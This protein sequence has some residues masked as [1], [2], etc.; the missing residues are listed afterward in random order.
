ME[1]VS[2]IGREK[3]GRLRWGVLAMLFGVTIINYAVRAALS[4]AAPSLSKDLGIDPLQLGIVFSAFGWSYVIAQVPG[5]WLLDRFGAPRVYL[6]VIVA[7]SLITVAHGT[8]VWLSGT[9]AVTA[10]FAL[11]FLVG[12]AEAPSFPANARVVASWFP[13]RERGTAS[14]VFN[15]AQYFATVLFAPL[16]GWIVADF[17]WPWVFV[18]MGAL[19]LVVSLFWSRVVRD[20]RDHPRLGAGELGLLIEGGALV[21]PVAPQVDAAAAKAENRRKMRVLL[22]T[23]T[24]WGLYSGQFFINTLTYFFIT[25]FPVYL[26]QERGL[27]VMK[28][29]LFATMPAVCGFIGGVLGGIW[30]DWLLR[31]GVSLTWARKVPVVAGMLGA[32]TILGCNFVHSNT[33]VLLFMSLAFFGKGVGALGWAVVAD[34]APRDSAGLSGGIF[35]MFGN[36]SSITTPILI[37]WI[38]KETGSFD[39]VLMLVAGSALAAALSYLFL[40]GKIERIGAQ[41]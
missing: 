25:W 31:R 10:L 22:T 14:A 13:A 36:I 7:W 24:L 37:G 41:A 20:P 11:R 18:A 1:A 27:S 35:N 26:V 3:V 2:K 34:V 39:L 40:V 29:G 12:L 5:G 23:P 32:L 8:V 33:L 19:G 6:W 9:A 30:S 21:D 15:A 28:A 17:G 4:L 38:L 16:M